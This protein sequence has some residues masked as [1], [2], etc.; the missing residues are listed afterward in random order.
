M[1]PTI[2]KIALVGSGECG[3]TT[4]VNKLLTGKFDKKYVSTLGVEVHPIT[5]QTNKG[6]I[7]FNIWDCAGQGKY[8]GLSDGYYILSQGA[9]VMYQGNSAASHERVDSYMEALDRV[10]T[11]NNI[12]IPKVIVASK[13][14]LGVG[15]YCD[16]EM[17]IK[18]EINIWE[19][20]L[21]LA[22]KIRGD[23]ALELV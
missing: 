16:V 21:E 5:L 22:R 20:L 17:S 18:N 2:Y 23:D 3:K 1:Q 7:T 13:S 11:K 8:A 14:E 12:C 19:P 4:W 15:N 9:I 6:L 10:C